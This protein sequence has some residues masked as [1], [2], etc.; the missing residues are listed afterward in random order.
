MKKTIRQSM[1]WFHS[2]IGL[3]FGWLL[4]A[5]FLTGS[6]SYYKNEIS[7]W[8]QPHFALENIEQKI[9]IKSA[10]EYL[11]KNAADAKIWNITVADQLSP[12]NK[13]YWQKSD[14]AY[15]SK[16][17]NANT[18]AELS[19]SSALGGDFF[20]S[21][22]FQLYGLPYL[23]GRLIVTLAAIV[24]LIALISGVITHKKIFADFFTLRTFKSQ[25]S[26]LDFHN[27][28]SVIALPFF[29]T[30][31]FTGIA[32]FFYI[33]FPSGMKKLYPEN[34]FQYFDEIR[35]VVSPVVVPKQIIAMKSPDFYLAET[36]KRW[37]VTDLANIIVQHPNTESSQ[38]II[39]E[40]ED[41]SI[42]YH[43][44]Q[45]NF[46]GV[47]GKL[48]NDT[49]NRS[50]IG[51]LNAS[52][53]GL[54][55]AHF[56]SPFLKLVLFFSGILGCL[57]IASGLLLWS[58]KRDI[59]NKKQHFNF[60]HY[61][62]YRL[63]IS[64]F[65]GLP[66]AVLSYLYA[67]RLGY[68]IASKIN[69]EISIFFGSWLLIFAMSLLIQKQYLWKI[70]LKLFVIMS[71]LLPIFN[72]L[73]LINNHNISDFHQYWSFLRIDLFILLFGL[74]GWLLHQKI[75][76]IQTKFHNK[77]SQKILSKL[78]NKINNKVNQDES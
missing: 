64:T 41:K 70:F 29:L 24:M 10:F 66:I 21:F 33:I 42:S 74:F 5:I 40:K 46:N 7:L 54:H 69:Y 27:I 14:G 47:T 72:V 51:V 60:G 36:Y 78:S 35:T 61:L 28:S 43:P 62:V 58:L 39:T 45:I 59:Q 50:P 11:E 9:A 67:N 57:M 52:M 12:V 6:L 48:L 30:M 17:L 18:G 8:M 32:I 75:V 44:A 65:I 2:W 4:F 25:R 68:I 31:T 16:T 49:R 63:N 77:L 1:A 34:P 71:I 56:A 20:Y 13:I 55:M 19:G 3:I 15:E 22:H 38:I 53:Y 23:I 73:T 76:P 37:G 26:Y